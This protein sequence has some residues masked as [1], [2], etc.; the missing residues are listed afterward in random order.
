MKDEPGR[1]NQEEKDKQVSKRAK[2]KAGK[3]IN[4]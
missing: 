1:T 2:A 4:R 3:N